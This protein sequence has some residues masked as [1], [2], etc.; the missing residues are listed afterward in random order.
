LQPFRRGAQDEEAGAYSIL[1]LVDLR[2]HLADLRASD[3][4][5]DATRRPGR[6]REI[7]QVDLSKKENHPAR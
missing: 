5:G 3:I 6:A 1:Q 4:Y 2:S 7:A